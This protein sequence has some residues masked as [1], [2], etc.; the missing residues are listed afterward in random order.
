MWP[1]I[2]M[3]V[4]Q[5]VPVIPSLVTD[6]ESLFRGKQK[7]GA[8]KWIAIEQVLSAPIAQLSSELAAVAPAGSKPQEIAKHVAIYTKAINDAT[9]A[10][11]N[12]IGA[13]P[14]STAPAAIGAPP[15]K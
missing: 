4:T 15:A 6:V 7:A 2:L 5:V 3:F 10:F 1:L 9:V 13:F 12:A 8:Q 11:A 14:S